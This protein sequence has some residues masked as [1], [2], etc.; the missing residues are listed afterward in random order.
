MDIVYGYVKKRAR[1]IY[2]NQYEKYYEPSKKRKIF[3]I[4]LRAKGTSTNEVHFNNDGPILRLR[5]SIY[6]YRKRC[7]IALSLYLALVTRKVSH[8]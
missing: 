2:S 4:I 1:K 7:L 5:P 8:S 3:V 6:S